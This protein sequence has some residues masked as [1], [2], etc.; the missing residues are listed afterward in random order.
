MHCFS[1]YDVMLTHRLQIARDVKLCHE[2]SP[3]EHVWDIAESALSL[4][5]NTPLYMAAFNDRSTSDGKGRP[6]SLF[7]AYSRDLTI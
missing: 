3:V 6:S 5:S 7:A 1:T 4:M 2:Q